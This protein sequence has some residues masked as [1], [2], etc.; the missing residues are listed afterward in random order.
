MNYLSAILFFVCIVLALTNPTKKTGKPGPTTTTATTA[1]STTSSLARALATTTGKGKEVAGGKKQHPSPPTTLALAA[2]TAT[3][4]HHKSKPK[5][6]S[7]AH[8]KLSKQVGT[9]KGNVERYYFDTATQ[10]CTKFVYTG[11][12][13]NRNNF[14]TLAK[15]NKACKV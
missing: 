15:C 14:P 6:K 4:K 2:A 12:Q 11:C 8:C 3:T 7:A 9:C 1:P 13:G 10:Q 5:S